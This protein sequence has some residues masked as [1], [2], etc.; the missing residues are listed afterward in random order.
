MR[1][2]ASGDVVR[3]LDPV[4]ALRP[5]AAPLGSEL[6]PPRHPVP[7]RHA[8]AGSDGTEREISKRVLSRSHADLD[9][10]RR[11]VD[12]G[13]DQLHRRSQTRSD[14]AAASARS[15]R[16]FH[17]GGHAAHFA[18][19]VAELTLLF[20]GIRADLDGLRRNTVDVLRQPAR[21]TPTGSC[22]TR[23]TRR[24][25]AP[26]RRRSSAS[27]S[28]AASR[29]ARSTRA[30]S[31]SCRISS[32]R[33]TGCPTSDLN[34]GGRPHAGAR[35]RAAGAG[36]RESA[37]ASGHSAPAQ[38]G[39]GRLLSGLSPGAHGGGS[40][41]RALPAR[42]RLSDRQPRHRSGAAR[43]TTGSR[44]TAWTTTTCCE[45]SPARDSRPAIW[46]TNATTP[47]KQASARADEM[48][49]SAEARPY[50]DDA[51]VQPGRHIRIVHGAE[52]LAD[53]SDGEDAMCDRFEA[54]VSAH[55]A[56][57]A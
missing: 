30:R 5:G 43:R 38:P 36:H 27:G 52:L 4:H 1:F 6:P 48:M 33:C 14:R 50:P 51:A 17:E 56:A 29:C 55:Y 23:A 7:R 24:R 11:A 46:P 42:A 18:N 40:N 28:P 35:N 31:P 45:G 15:T 26:S 53:S 12:A 19:V 16:S 13:G 34:A 57:P 9:D 22:D 3:R 2:F 8:A 54:W 32:R 47:L 21:R 39:V 20:A 10:E 37:A 25:R 44:A 49:R 41:T